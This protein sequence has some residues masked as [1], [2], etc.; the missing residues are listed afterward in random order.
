MNGI[1]LLKNKYNVKT[2]EFKV[3]T[4][5]FHIKTKK[6]VMKNGLTFTAEKDFTINVSHYSG[7]VLTNAMHIDE[8]EK[9]KSTIIRID[10]KVSGTGSH[11]CG[12]PLPEQYRLNDKEIN[13]VFYIS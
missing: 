11:S 6:L 1:K 13:F 7:R 2:L 4:L 9:D 10:Y 8:V 12:Y 3:L 5:Y